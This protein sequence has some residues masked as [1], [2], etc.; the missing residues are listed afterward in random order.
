M[1]K[2]KPAIYDIQNHPF[3]RDRI[4]GNTHLIRLYNQRKLTKEDLAKIFE[5]SEDYVEWL[6][7][8]WPRTEAEILE[9]S[10]IPPLPD[11]ALA[12][13]ISFKAHNL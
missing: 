4:V 7:T 11:N 10:I 8:K 12:N 1:L 5:T 2:L 13:L 9:D 6:L 3:F